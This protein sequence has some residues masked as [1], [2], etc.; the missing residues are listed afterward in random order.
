[1][2]DRRFLLVLVT[3]LVLA[4]GVSALFYRMVASTRGGRTEMKDAVVATQPM[5]AGSIVKA[6]MV[7]V[8]RVPASSVPKGSFSKTEEV[9]GRAVLSNVLADEVVVEGRL[10]ARGGGFGLA[11]LIPA[12]MRAASVRVNDVVGVAG[13]ALPGMRVDVLVTGRPGDSRESVTS[14]VLQDVQVLSAGQQITPD[15]KGAAVTVQV[16]TLL[17]SPPDAE[18]LTLANAEGHIHLV[19]RNAADRERA[20]TPGRNLAALYKVAGGA[21]AA[22][23]PAARKPPAEPAETKR[24]IRATPPPPAPAAPSQPAPPE[25]DRVVVM[26]GAKV[27]VAT[28]QRAGGE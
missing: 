10:A 1:M 8:T 5:P 6:E 4:A 11:P 21:A 25:P 28:F 12:G 20:A 7:R 13:F 26:N 19:L 9:A 17:V 22:P 16:V 15:P 14:T 24:A 3:S 2:L 23:A 18:T 27:T